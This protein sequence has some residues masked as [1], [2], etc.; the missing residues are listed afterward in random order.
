MKA[1]CCDLVG[2]LPNE[3]VGGE[4]LPGCPSQWLL[5]ATKSPISELIGYESELLG[6]TLLLTDKGLEL[7]L[8]GHLNNVCRGVYVVVRH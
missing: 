8:R 1:K 3:W 6:H 5:P 4:S 7:R 2:F